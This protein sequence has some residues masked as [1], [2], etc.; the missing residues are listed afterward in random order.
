MLEISPKTFEM[1]GLSGIGLHTTVPRKSSLSCCHVNFELVAQLLARWMKAFLPDREGY[2]DTAFPSYALR[3]WDILHLKVTLAHSLD[4]ENQSAVETRLADALEWWRLQ[5]KNTFLAWESGKGKDI[6]TIDLS[7][8]F[9]S[10]REKNERWA[11]WAVI[12]NTILPSRGL[13]RHFAL[14]SAC[15]VSGSFRA[16][17][18]IEMFSLATAKILDDDPEWPDQDGNIDDGAQKLMSLCERFL[19]TD[20]EGMVQFRDHEIANLLRRRIVGFSRD[21][22][23]FLAVA[24]LQKIEQ[25]GS[26]L[27]FEPWH[28][29]Q[30]LQARFPSHNYVVT[31]WQ[32]HY[33]LV[34]K[35]ADQLPGQLQMLLLKAW[36]SVSHPSLCQHQKAK[37][38]NF[39]SSIYSEVVYVGFE[40]CSKFG[41]DGLRNIY[42]RMGA[43]DPALNSTPGNTRSPHFNDIQASTYDG[44]SNVL[45]AEDW[46][47]IESI[48]LE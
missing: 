27:L 38:D 32:Y 30:S 17:T 24:C 22:H 6:F 21:S 26:H 7:D 37:I 3:D 16:L 29:F 33:R 1:L 42:E 11:Q 43:N 45:E 4:T 9:S 14:R 48:D 36:A 15:C 44:D 8:S 40:F 41:F 39:T 25:M 2:N 34:E 13:A 23:H 47:M 35:H 31:F 12:W 28:D 5:V 19:D 18:A 10:P 20:S 46:Q